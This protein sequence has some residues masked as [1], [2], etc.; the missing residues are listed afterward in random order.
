MA[1]FHPAFE[2][3]AA[4]WKQLAGESEG[5]SGRGIFP[6]S[7]EYT[8][9][10]HSLGQWVQEGNRNLFETFLLLD[11]SRRHV[12]VPGVP[13]D[14]EGL[15]YLQGKSL[16]FINDKAYKGTAQAHLE[17]GAPNMSI[18]VKNRDPYTLGQLFYFFERGIAMSG[19]LSGVNPFDQP[20]VE[21]YKKN[22]FALLNKPGFEKRKL[23]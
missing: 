3:V 20:G 15:N 4:W 17:G 16:D 7:V 5:K 19:Y 21:F 8:T 23:L 10:L 2:Y 18:T 1:S 13:N 14:V 9:D 12:T 22:M 11:A 6:A